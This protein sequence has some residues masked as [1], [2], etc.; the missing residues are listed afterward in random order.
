[1][2]KTFDLI[3]QKQAEKLLKVF[4]PGEDYFYNELSGLAGEIALRCAQCRNDYSR[5][6]ALY[7][8]LG[9]MAT[10][11]QLCACVDDIGDIVAQGRD[12]VR[13]IR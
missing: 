10:M 9:N 13:R 11:I 6:H 12:A 5:R 2:A 1:M 8:A 3:S 7:E 4:C